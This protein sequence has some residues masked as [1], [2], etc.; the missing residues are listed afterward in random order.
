MRV[1]LQCPL[2]GHRGQGAVTRAPG[3]PGEQEQRGRTVGLG[4]VAGQVQEQVASVQAAA[5]DRQPDRVPDLDAGQGLGVAGGLVVAPSAVLAAGGGE[6]G[7]LGA[8]GVALAPAGEGV[9]DGVLGRGLQER[10]EP[11]GVGDGRQDGL[12]VLA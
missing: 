7:P 10:D 6:Q 2:D 4:Q 11:V 8:G 1:G 3:L 9:V 5:V 12:E